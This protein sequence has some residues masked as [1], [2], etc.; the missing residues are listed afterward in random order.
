M[1]AEGIIIVSA[2]IMQ[3]PAI[4]AAK[5]LGLFV[6]ASDRDPNAPGF[7]FC[8]ER[9]ILDSK[10]VEGHIQ[11]ARQNC[12][13]FGI[14]GAFAGSDVAVTV[15][16]I[17][18]ALSFP[19]ISPE[20]AAMSNN[21]S[22]MKQRWLR[23]GI[24]TPRGE[25]VATLAEAQLAIRR[26]GFPAIIKAVDNAA[27]RGSQKL[28]SLA[29]LPTAFEHACAAS[30]TNT[31]M[32]EQYVV[33]SE[34]SVETIV[35]RG[36][37]YHVGMAD[38]EF[39]YHP[40]HIETAH[41]DPS[42]LSPAVQ[43]RIYEVVDAAAESLGIDFGPA[44]ADMILTADGPM[45]LEMPARLSGGFHSQYT[46]P[47]STGQE[48]IKAVL[49]MAVGRPLDTAFLEPTMDRTALCSG[50][51]PPP[52]RISAVSGVDEARALEGVEKVILTR[53]PGDMVQPYIDNG[54]R[55][56]WVITTGADLAEARARFEH[57][58]SIIRIEID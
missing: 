44:K 17:T 26:V 27:S 58:A 11:Y 32:I 19:G 37:H 47:L 23:D 35:W 51:F 57:A 25:E 10:D 38:R 4:R 22:L 50:I 16:G 54:G 7:E 28:T 30:R 55:F 1:N 9:V 18:D 33:G 34:Q 52:G 15:A 21:K 53:G 40:F 43:G 20:V 46:T 2:G 56:C 24:A 42:R 8:D 12:G 6:V 3:V 36:R 5:E 48:P 31:A 13:R 29:E 49:G 41:C 39:G 14:R 45:I